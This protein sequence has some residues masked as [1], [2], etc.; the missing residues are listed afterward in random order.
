MK[1]LKSIRY[2]G[3]MEHQCIKTSSPDGLYMTDDHIITHNTVFA[4]VFCAVSQKKGSEVYLEPIVNLFEASPF[5]QRIRT[6]GEMKDEEHR[7]IESTEIEYIPWTSSSPSSVL[8]TGNGLNWKLIAA[9]NSLLGVNILG[10]AMTELSF[11]H[12][13][14]WALDYNE[15]IRMEDG[16]T[17]LMRDLK[18]GDRLD[19]PDKKENII[20]KI[21]FDDEDDLYEIQFDDGRTIGCNLNHWWKV[22]FR[23]NLYGEKIWELVQTKFMLDHSEFE[24]EIPEVQ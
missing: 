5:F 17:K 4:L 23:K 11:F 22:S 13:A 9:S 21:P 7:L 14:G 19:H 3:E 6:H 2:I 20:E 10:G 24:F 8:Q 1:K 12:E 15:E 16:T 18:I